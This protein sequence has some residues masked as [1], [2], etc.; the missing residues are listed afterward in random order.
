[1]VRTLLR[2]A[3]SSDSQPGQRPE[4]QPSRR[5]HETVAATTGFRAVSSGSATVPDAVAL[6]YLRHHLPYY[7]ALHAH[8][9]TPA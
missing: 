7:E 9:L 8:R 6:P 4:W 5:W 1:M 2:C 3:D